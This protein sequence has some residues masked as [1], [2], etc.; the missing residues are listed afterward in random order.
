MSLKASAPSLFLVKLVKFFFNWNS[1]HKRVNS[2]YKAWSYK[3]KE[4]K[5]ITAYRKPLQKE[6]T[7]KGIQII[8]QRKAFFR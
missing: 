4:H 5:K 3:K 2:H 8:G 6:P 7:V 1:L